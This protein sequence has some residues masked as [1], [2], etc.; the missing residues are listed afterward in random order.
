MSNQLLSDRLLYCLG[1]LAILFR[2]A[3]IVTLW[4]L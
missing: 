1:G 2:V 4:G 3:V